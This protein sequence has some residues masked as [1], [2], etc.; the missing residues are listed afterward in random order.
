MQRISHIFTNINQLQQ[1]RYQLLYVPVIR[2]YIIKAA[3]YDDNTIDSL[4][5]LGDNIDVIEEDEIELTYLVTDLSLY[6][7]EILDK[8][9]NPP[10]YHHLD[11]SETHNQKNEK[12]LHKRKS[13]ILKKKILKRFKSQNSN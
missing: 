4:S 8:N 6:P 1:Y 7:E 11:G 13:E 9:P 3:I 2:D 10:K 5:K 12:V